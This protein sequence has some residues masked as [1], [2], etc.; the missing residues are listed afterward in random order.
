MAQTITTIVILALIALLMAFLIHK[1]APII[2]ARI[3]GPQPLFSSATN[4]SFD[5]AIGHFKGFT[6]RAKTTF[7]YR[8]V[9]ALDLDEAKKL[10]KYITKLHSL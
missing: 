4:Q 3:E 8:F 2:M 10:Q 5:T 7:M 6:D 9:A 1:I